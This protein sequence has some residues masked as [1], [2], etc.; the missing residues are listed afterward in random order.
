MCRCKECYSEQSRI[1]PIL[2]P[3]DCL[4]KH[5]QYICGT[6]GRCICIETDALRGLRRW[7]F[8]FKSL[9]IAKLYLRV[10]DVCMKQCCGIYEI[11]QNNGRIFY[12]IFASKE[13]LTTYLL[14]SKDKRCEHEEPIHQWDSF[15]E[16][17][18]TKIKKLSED[19][20]RKYMEERASAPSLIKNK[21]KG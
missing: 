9:E 11:K 7:N 14:K 4:K 5:T 13:D 17:P 15:Q 18:N 10:A 20:I 12:K 8:P 1:T 16:Y 6:C 19:E 21:A 3:E 2:N